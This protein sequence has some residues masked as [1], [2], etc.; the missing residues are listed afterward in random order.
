[1]AP[2]VAA[3]PSADSG[4]ALITL[5]PAAAP[6][7]P[8]TIGAPDGITTKVFGLETN[9][10]GPISASGPVV[11]PEGTAAVSWAAL[12]TVNAAPCPPNSTLV[13]LP[14]FVPWITTDVPSVP[15]A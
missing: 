5:K 13:V 11:A 7:K 6:L 8:V 9:P 15:E 3:A 14:R 4:E 2:V 1:M 10:E 12:S